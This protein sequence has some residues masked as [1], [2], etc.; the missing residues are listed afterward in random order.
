[1]N[2]LAGLHIY[3]LYNVHLYF[4][5]YYSILKIISNYEMR[6][7]KSLAGPVQPEA[8]LI[9]HGR[10]DSLSPDNLSNCIAYM[11]LGAIRLLV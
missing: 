9:T 8:L 4:F 11:Y 2:M 6:K 1:M 7:H 5:K 3:C 10:V